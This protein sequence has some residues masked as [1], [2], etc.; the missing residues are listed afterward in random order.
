MAQKIYLLVDYRGY[1]Y[2]S[3]SSRG[4]SMK[5]DLLTSFFAENGFDLVVRRFTDIDLRKDDYRGRYVL[6]QSS[7]DRDLH[8]KSYIEDIMLAL[9]YQGAILIPDFY[10]LRAH[11]NKVFMEL[12]RDLSSCA[13][14]KSIVSRVYGTYEDYEAALSSHGH[15]IVLKPASGALSAGVKLASCDAEK[16]KYAREISG[17]FHLLDWLKNL[18]NTYIREGYV[19]KSRRRKKFVVQNFIPGLKGDYKILVYFDK[20]YVLSRETRKNDFRASGSGI[21]S[22]PKEL[23]PG[24]LDYARLVFDSFQVPF[25]SLDVACLQD[26]F[27]LIEFQMLSFGTYTIEKSEF[28]FRSLDGGWQLSCEAP[29]LEREVARSVAKHLERMAGRDSKEGRLLA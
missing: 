17:S 24:L 23:P 16:R 28:Y 13:Y 6:Y 22:Y 1:F 8:Y 25:L 18:V 5:L 10:S 26:E 12:L 21:F 20:Y 27:S 4:A 29:V 15:D 19:Q 9:Q 14:I 11:H 2:S 7:E 3:V